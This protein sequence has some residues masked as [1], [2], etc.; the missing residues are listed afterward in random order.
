MSRFVNFSRTVRATA[1]H[2]ASPSSPRQLPELLRRAA[3]QRLSVRTVG[4]GHSFT[5]LVQTDGMLLTLDRFQGLEEVDARTHE[6]TF[7]AGTRLWQ[8]PGLLKPFGLALANM[9]DVDRQSIAGAISTGTHGT[10]LRFIS[11]SGA[12]TGLRLVSAGGQTLRASA[13]E[14]PRIFQAARLG[15]G[16]LGV[17]THVRLQC[18]PAY[19]LQA[20][21]D[22][23]PID[24]VA[25]EFLT[26][27]EIEDHL[28]FFW[29]PGT[30]KA[31]VKTNTRQRP[32]G[33]HRPANALARWANDEVLSNGALWLACSIGATAPRLIPHVNRLA[34]GALS[35]RGYTDHPHRVFVSARRVRFTEMEYALPLE[36]F[37]AA[38]HAI[39][40]HVTRHGAEVVFPIEVRTAA[41]ED[42]WLGTASGRRSV[43][44]AV[45]RHLRDRASRYFQA[46]E[47]ILL[48]FEGRPHWG[49]EH[50]LAA[51]E[52]AGLYPHF[53]DFQQVRAELDPQGLFLN[54]YLRRLLLG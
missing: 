1:R 12:V 21:E 20:R 6:V 36:H 39:R 4:A 53:G 33:R 51:G 50:T 16:V 47:R 17:I 44:I 5:P 45:H 25:E 24:Q 43:Y 26:R 42:T 3:E 38:F 32:D 23:E 40:R 29:F 31:L 52:L 41:S 46:L 7:R 13:T 10:G 8:V 35:A 48:S 11:L 49:K 37:G 15:L 28:E 30:R 34:T 19:L 9:G 18:V 22:I 27:S 14:N 54:D 2:H